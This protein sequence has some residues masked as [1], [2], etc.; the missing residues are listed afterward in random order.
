[1]LCDVFVDRE[2][3]ARQ[4]EPCATKLADRRRKAQLPH[5]GRQLNE[6]AAAV[7]AWAMVPLTARD[8]IRVDG[9]EKLWLR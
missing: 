3:I 5:A 7:A 4:I 2:L 1:M 8:K 6:V 9:E